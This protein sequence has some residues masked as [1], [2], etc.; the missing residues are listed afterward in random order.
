MPEPTSTAPAQATPS[1]PAAQSQEK[2][3]A[4]NT[5]AAQNNVM[6]PEKNES[7]GKFRLSAA[8][9]KVAEDKARKTNEEDKPKSDKKTSTPPQKAKEEKKPETESTAK[10]KEEIETS[11]V[12]KIKDPI[13]SKKPTKEEGA[14]K[15]DS[16]DDK[17]IEDE[18]SNPHHSEKSAKRFRELHR[19]W[20]E[21][22]SKAARTVEEI[23]QRDAKLTALEKEMAEIKNGRGA[24]DD[25]IKRDQE[26]LKRF[27]RRYEIDKDPEFNTRFNDRIKITNDVIHG[28]LLK[29]GVKKE[30]A[31]FIASNG[32][33]N[34]YIEQ[35]PEGAETFLNALSLGDRQKIQTALTEQQ[36]VARA[37][38][39][40]IRTETENADK[41]F[42]EKERAEAEARA[43]NPDPSKIAEQEKKVMNDWSESVI[44]T[45]P[46]FQEQEIPGDAAP[47]VRTRLEDENKFAAELREQLKGNL[48]P[49][50]LQERVDIALAATL[51]HRLKRRLDETTARITELEK[52]NEALKNDSATTPRSGNTTT[53]GGSESG[54]PKAPVKGLGAVL[55]AMERGERVA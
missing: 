3:P 8:I 18:L 40:F 41:Y 48:Q 55:D 42:Q 28:I 38:D 15:D 24:S 10:D 23:K 12:L 20:K 45:L 37:R 47:E 16:V 9:D 25:Q 39:E 22:D 34:A 11:G 14:S 52:E 27:R 13:S 1:A 2:A 21:A 32:G 4:Q 31:D 51:A 29:N 19:R 33:F 50:N 54:R 49:K 7:L 46:Y 17:E 5:P 30:D 36:L 44:K 53:S 43:K 6:G 35:N 26:D